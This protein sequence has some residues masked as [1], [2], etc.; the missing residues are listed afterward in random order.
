MIKDTTFGIRFH[1][2]THAL[3][4]FLHPGQLLRCWTLPLSAWFGIQDIR[5]SRLPVHC[6]FGAL[7]LRNLLPAKKPRMRHTTRCFGDTP[8]DPTMPHQIA[9]KTPPHTN[10]MRKCEKILNSVG[11]SHAKPAV[12][13]KITRIV[14]MI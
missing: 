1:L 6:W 14:T 10:V 3:Q 8:S 11:I 4:E 2:E 12:T 13:P 9:Q 7:H 5:L